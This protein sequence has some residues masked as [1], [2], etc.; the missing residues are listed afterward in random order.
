MTNPNSTPPNPYSYTP[1]GGNNAPLGQP[2]GPAGGPA[3]GP[4]QPPLGQGIYGTNQAQNAPVT[5]TAPG[6]QPSGIQQQY[7]LPPA[8]MPQGAPQQP[9]KSNKGCLISAIIGFVVFIALIIVAAMFVVPMISRMYS[10]AP[11][12]IQ[13]QPMLT[14]PLSAPSAPSA[15]NASTNSPGNN[16][17]AAAKTS[18]QQYSD[19]LSS[20]KKDIYE[21]LVKHDN[22]TPET[23]QEAVDSLNVDWKE[24]A[25]KQAEVYMNDL[26]MPI[27][28]IY[29][30]LTSEYGGQF[31]SEEAQYAVDTLKERS[32]E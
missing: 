15:P 1:G 23:A 22:F 27:D 12:S 20:S 29:K 2:N 26:N 30:Q 3:G 13:T 6:T 11:S 21:M 31:T 24:N 4:P 5:G 19:Y 14:S 10:V 18:A 7:G 17:I 25:L 9:K 8:G 32:H 16:D 28:Q